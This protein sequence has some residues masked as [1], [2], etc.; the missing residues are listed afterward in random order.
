MVPVA[1]AGNI[2]D[3]AT[4]PSGNIFNEAMRTLLAS[5]ER[6]LQARVVVDALLR[7]LD[8]ASSSQPPAPQETAHANAATKF[9]RRPAAGKRGPR[10]EHAGRGAARRTDKQARPTNRKNP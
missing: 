8:T 10:V 6:L 3:E 9:S 7:R 5:C 4:T 1:V 2:L